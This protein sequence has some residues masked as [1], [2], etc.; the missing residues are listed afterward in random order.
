MLE[1]EK[2]SIQRGLVNQICS[3]QWWESTRMTLLL[4]D[5]ISGQ[6]QCMTVDGKNKCLLGNIGQRVRE[7]E[8]N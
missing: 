4:I 6:V 2:E 5:F 8:R 7:R 1:R 3:L